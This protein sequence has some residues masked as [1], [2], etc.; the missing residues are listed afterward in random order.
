MDSKTCSMCKIDKP[1]SAF[2]THARRGYQSHCKECNRSNKKKHYIQNKPAYK[3]QARLFRVN[4]SNYV[5]DIKA[6]TPCADCGGM[7]HPVAMDFDHVRGKKIKEVSKL[8]TQ[9][10][11]GLVREEILKCEIVCSNC[12]RVR[13]HKRIKLVREGAIEPN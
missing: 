12:H 5:S 2:Y 8:V 11:S 6:K 7:F 10:S 9:C 3:A 1:L 4:L 13:T